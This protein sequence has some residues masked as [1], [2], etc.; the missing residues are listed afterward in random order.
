MTSQMGV[1]VLSG[2]G[3]VLLQH[4]VDP[5]SRNAVDGLQ[6]SAA[7]AQVSHAAVPRLALQPLGGAVARRAVQAAAAAQ[8]RLRLVLESGQAAEEGREL[9]FG[10]VAGGGEPERRGEGGREGDG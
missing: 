1:L 5:V 3:N 8:P 6:R 10:P 2:S 7:D 4:H 9:L